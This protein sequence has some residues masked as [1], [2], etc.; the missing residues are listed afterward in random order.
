VRCGSGEVVGGV[1]EPSGAGEGVDGVRL[2]E[3]SLMTWSTVSIASNCRWETRL[4]EFGRR[5]PSVLDQ[6]VNYL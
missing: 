3:G 2:V 4:E 1:L 6:G 5:W